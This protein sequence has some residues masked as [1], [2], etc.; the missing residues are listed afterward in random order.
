M[1]VKD[2]KGGHLHN[3][4]ISVANASVM[5]ARLGVTC[6]AGVLCMAHLARV[7]VCTHYSRNQARLDQLQRAR[8]SSPC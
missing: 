3:D 6:G 8:T 1:P 2:T 5:S 7:A 4:F